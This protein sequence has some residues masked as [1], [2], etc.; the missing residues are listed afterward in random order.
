VATVAA[1]VNQADVFE[2]A[3]VFRDRGLFEAESVHDISDRAFIDREKGKDIAAARFCDGVEGVGGGGCT[4]HAE[5]IHAH[6]GI[7]QLER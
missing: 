4:R 7:C 1:N 5:R 6:M 2:D 3:E